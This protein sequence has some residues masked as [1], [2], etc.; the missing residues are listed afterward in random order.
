MT[1]PLLSSAPIS[2]SLTASLED[3]PPAAFEA[4]TP[5]G[6]TQI[7]FWLNAGP[8]CP[9]TANVA[10]GRKV[11]QVNSP[12][13]F[14]AL[15]GVGPTDDVTQAHTFYARTNIGGFK[16]QFTFQDS[17]TAVVPLFGVLL[18]EPDSVGSLAIV[19]VSVQGVGTIEYYAAGAD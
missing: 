7:P 1:Q 14:V 4:Q 5:S 10:T 6:S 11:R 3:G 18:L 16:L 13:A 9:K 15:S 12:S 19:G 8:N 17:S 2:V